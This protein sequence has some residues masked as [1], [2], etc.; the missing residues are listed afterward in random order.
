MNATLKPLSFLCICQCLLNMKFI[1]QNSSKS[2]INATGPTQTTKIK[3]WEC[4]F[5]TNQ[6]FIQQVS[7]LV[8]GEGRREIGLIQ[9][10]HIVSFLV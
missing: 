9:M 8:G 2:I 5:S 6:M 10:A 7:Y 3:F 1:I 4:S